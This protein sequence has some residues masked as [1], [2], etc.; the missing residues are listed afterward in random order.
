M[1][2]LS[3]APSPADVLASLKA[4]FGPEGS[5]E[6]V[7]SSAPAREVPAVSEPPKPRTH[8]PERATAIIEAARAAG[9]H[10]PEDFTILIPPGEMI[11]P[12][13]AVAKFKEARPHFF[14][15]SVAEMDAKE[16]AA[17]KREVIRD[18]EKQQRANNQTA[19]MARLSRK[20]ST[21]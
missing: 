21:K 13:D 6:P 5:A 4:I 9:A 3:D 19:M 8:T 16:F 17:A 15:K 20:Y 7:Q 18:A 12:T 2:I 11:N 14:K 10:H 1:D